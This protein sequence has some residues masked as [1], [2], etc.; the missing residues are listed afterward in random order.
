[1]FEIAIA[2]CIV[3]N[4]NSVYS[5]GKSICNFYGPKVVFEKKIE[6]EKEKLLISE[7][8]KEE[9][10]RLYPTA[11]KINTSAICVLKKSSF[12]QRNLLKAHKPRLI[13]IQK[14]N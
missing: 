2:F 10:K 4:E 3:L 8:F 5:G 6:C 9:V 11:K 12:L 1:V 13:K 14:S 7:W